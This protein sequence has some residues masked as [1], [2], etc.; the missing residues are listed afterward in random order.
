MELNRMNMTQLR[1]LA[2]EYKLMR[3]YILRKN[4][5]IN[6]IYENLRKDESHTTKDLPVQENTHTQ[7]SEIDE[8]NKALSKRQLKRRA[9]K[10]SKLS[11]KSKNLR[12]EINDLKS[13]K[14]DLEDKVKKA[15]SSTSA[16]FKGK[17][18]LSMKQLR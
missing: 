7:Q 13:E 16:R 15:S 10:A 2:K 9:Q 8:L 6:L 11:N 12:I 4:E 3:Y 14:E 17:K 18:I 5:L 1:A